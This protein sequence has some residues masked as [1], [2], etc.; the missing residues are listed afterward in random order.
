M[1]DNVEITTSLT[2]QD[3][4]RKVTIDDQQW[5]EELVPKEN[6]V[7]VEGFFS[8]VC[9]ERGKIVPGTRREGKNV[10]TLTGREYYAR[11]SS[12]SSYSPLTKAR[13]DAIRY[14]GFGIG[15]TP[16]VSTVSRLVSPIAYDT[17][18]AGVFLA[19]LDIPSYP[20]ASS[21]S[22]GTVVRYSREFSETE[23]S[24]SSTVL[25][26]EAGLFTDGSPSSSFTPGTRNRFI[27]QANL[28]APN[29]YKSFEA[30]PKTQNFV[31]QTIWQ[32]RF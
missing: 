1:K 22:F 23:L 24:T 25:L 32:I 10:I 5:I 29:A 4:T 14:I 19:E 18:G 9:R 2:I 20:F 28:Q 3:E 30:F 21:G 12:Y 27:A 16:A 7:Y 15:S 8:S 13:Q 6:P 11:C 26:T 17:T 31:L